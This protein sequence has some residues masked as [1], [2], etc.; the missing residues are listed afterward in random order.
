ME[1][2]PKDWMF[3][4]W[5]G[6]SWHTLDEITGF[7]GWRVVTNVTSGVEAELYSYTFAFTNSASF[8]K[9]RLSVSDVNNRDSYG[10]YF[11]L[12]EMQIWGYV[13][14]SLAGVVGLTTEGNDIDFVQEGVNGCFTPTIT[15]SQYDHTSGMYVG[16]VARL[17]DKNYNISNGFLA[18]MG[19]DQDGEWAYAPLTYSYAIPQNYLAGKEMVLK[20]YAFYSRT[21]DYGQYDARMPGSW[22]V[23]GLADD[24]RWLV[25]DRKTG[26]NGWQ[27]DGS[28]R[29]YSAFDIDNNLSFRQY[30]IRVSA[31]V[32]LSGSKNQILLYEIGL[33]GAWGT[34]ISVPPPPPKG[35][36]VDFK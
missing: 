15:V 24:G 14:A 30:R 10:G 6:S 1:R 22:T 19:S 13:G 7:S 9:Y 12:T 20:R 26:Y 27:T 16:D 3:Q 17:F 34:G 25:L 5:D 29:Y 11:Q 4:G 36:V 28:N 32:G 35:L 31:P 8:R 33:N 23:E 21:D 18:R 2:M